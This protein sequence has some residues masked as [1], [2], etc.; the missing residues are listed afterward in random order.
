[1]TLKIKFII[2]SLALILGFGAG[3]QVS[4][5]VYTSKELRA[6]EA[7]V[8]ADRDLRERLFNV[9]RETQEAITNIKVENKTIYQETKREILR[10]PVYTECVLT[11]DGVTLVNKAR[12]H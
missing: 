10:E 3:F 5:W 12:G 1:M 2:G 6:L 4:Q 9:S 8:E 11:P 7:Q